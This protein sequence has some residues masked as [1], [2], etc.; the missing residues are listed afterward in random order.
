MIFRAFKVVGC[1]SGVSKGFRDDV[2]NKHGGF[3]VF[4]GK[5]FRQDSE[6]CWIWTFLILGFLSDLGGLEF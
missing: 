4:V 2:A 3:V 1:W 6:G 5:V